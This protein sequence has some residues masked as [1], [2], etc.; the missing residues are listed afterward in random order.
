[1]KAVLAFV[2]S[3]ILSIVNVNA[4]EYTV[5]KSLSTTEAARLGKPTEK[6]ADKQDPSRHNMN[7]VMVDCYTGISKSALPVIQFVMM[8]AVDHLQKKL[9]KDVSLIITRHTAPTSGHKSFCKDPTLDVC[10]EKIEIDKNAK[11]TNRK[12]I[13]C[14]KTG[15]LTQQGTRMRVTFKDVFKNP[16]MDYES[17]HVTMSPKKSCRY[18]LIVELEEPNNYGDTVPKA[19]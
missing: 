8:G 6:Q 18:N 3:F 15:N 12:K 17:F 1:M 5:L 7:R 19:T 4:G 16:D 9:F 10:L 13:E 2:L 11:I 14:V